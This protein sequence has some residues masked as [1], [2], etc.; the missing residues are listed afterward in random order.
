MPPKVSVVMS[1]YNAGGFLTE[2]VDSVLAQ[3]FE[4]FEFVIIDDGSTDGSLAA[5]QQ[6]TDPRVRVLPQENRGLIASLN[7]GIEES[8]GQLIARMDADDRCEAD[9]FAI[10][11]R[12]LDQHPEISL[13]GGSVAIMDEAGN[14]LSPKVGFPKTHETIWNGIGRRPWVFCHP[15]VMYRRSAA[16][17]TGMY[18]RDFAHAEDAEFFARLMTRYR[19]ANLPDV[20]LH[21]RL[22]RGGI[23]LSKLVHGQINARL[24]AKIIDRWRPGEEF[25]PT[26][27]E[28]SAADAAIAA[29][30]GTSTPSKIESAYQARVGRELLRGRQWGRALRHYGSAI[31]SDFTNRNAYAGLAAALLHVGGEPVDSPA[32]MTD[33][34]DRLSAA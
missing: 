26:A 32:R 1:V 17:A 19:A 20:L 3:T 14:P 15:A 11:V 9:R 18:R 30:Q 6:I 23:S 34:I 22:R 28:R 8:R 27:E 2:A 13:L 31:R 21:Y 12:Y 10:Q 7:R 16:I 25:A 33:S 5:L 24:V 29:S 4:D